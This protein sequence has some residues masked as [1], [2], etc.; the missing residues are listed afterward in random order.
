MQII[1]EIGEIG[2]HIGSDCHLLRPSLY[3]MSCLGDPEEIVRTYAGTMAGDMQDALAVIYACADDDLSSVFGHYSAADDGVEYTPGTAPIEHVLPIAQCLIKHG[4][5]G[6]LHPL[7]MRADE[8]PEYVTKF[9]ARDHVA[10][11]VAH[12]GVSERDAWNMTMTSLDGALRA[13]FPQLESNA[14][15]SRAPTIEEHDAT[16]AWHEQIAAIRAQKKAAH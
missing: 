13:K 3:A 4:I 2:V 14:P 10:L 1:T 8:E 6:A 9:V 16:M 7:P 12:L 11:A 5:T 15:G